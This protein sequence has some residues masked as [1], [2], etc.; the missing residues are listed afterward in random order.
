MAGTCATDKYT[1]ESDLQRLINQNYENSYKVINYGVQGGWDLINDFERILDTSLNKGDIV[2]QVEGE[3]NYEIIDKYG[4]KRFNNLSSLFDRPH[5]Y[6]YWSIDKYGHITSKGYE[7]VASYIYDIIKPDLNK[8]E[9][10][11]PVQTVKYQFENEVDTFLDDNPDLKNYLDGLK[12]VKEKNNVNGKIGS[13]V[14][15]CNPFTLGHRYLIEQAASQVDHLYI[16][17]VEEDKSVFPFKD[18]IDLVK[19]GVADLGDKVTVLP[20]GKWI[21]SLLTFPEYFSK[22]DKQEDIIDP[23]QDV[24]LFGKY[25]CPALGINKRFVG[26]EPFDKVTKQYNESMRKELPNFNVEFEEIPRKSVDGEDIISATKVRKALKEKDFETLKKYV[27][28]TTFDYLQENCESLIDA[29][30]AKYK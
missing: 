4:F 13:I 27:P 25:I 26:E 22:D 21:I 12:E 24:K 20:S 2:I 30:N 6:G 1:M 18:R 28:Q 7:V 9:P 17:V 3:M 16:F 15:N 14:M 29:I 10:T 11:E 19:K 5:N 23:S 8:N